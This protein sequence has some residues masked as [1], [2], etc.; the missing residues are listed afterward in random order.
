VSVERDGLDTAVGT[1]RVAD[2]RGGLTALKHLI[3]IG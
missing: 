2:Y 1:A 3:V